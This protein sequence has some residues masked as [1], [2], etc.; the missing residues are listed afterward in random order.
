M[1][2]HM[3]TLNVMKFFIYKNYKIYIW[4]IRDRRIN[5]LISYRLTSFWNTKS[6]NWLVKLILLMRKMSLLSV[7]R[8][9]LISFII[10]YLVGNSRSPHSTH[11]FF[12]K[13]QSHWPW[14]WVKDR[15]D[16]LKQ[17]SVQYICIL[18]EINDFLWIMKFF[19]FYPEIII[20]EAIASCKVTMDNTISC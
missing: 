12:A 15:T 13:G 18:Y 19:F 4:V 2:A 6:W 20:Q 10:N 16:F 5:N 9:I 11:Q 1:V 3:K 17:F 14:F 7:F 8:K